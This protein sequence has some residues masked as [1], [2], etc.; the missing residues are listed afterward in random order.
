MPLERLR[1]LPGDIDDTHSRV[2]SCPTTTDADAGEGPA[3]PV[4]LDLTS[5]TDGARFRAAG[6][7]RVVEQP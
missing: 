4:K 3:T 6:L 1:S 5:Q 2:T 7:R